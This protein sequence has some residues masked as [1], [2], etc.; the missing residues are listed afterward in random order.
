MIRPH[1]IS[2]AVFSNRNCHLEHFDTEQCRGKTRQFPDCVPG[3]V[4]ER[5]HR[6]LACAAPCNQQQQIL[7]QDIEAQGICSMRRVCQ[8]NVGAARWLGGE[9]RHQLCELFARGDRFEAIRLLHLTPTVGRCPRPVRLDGAAMQR[10]GKP[11][12]RT[13]QQ[14]A[15]TAVQGVVEIPTKFVSFVKSRQR[16]S[17]WVRHIRAGDGVPEFDP[18]WPPAQEELVAKHRCI[19]SQNPPFADWL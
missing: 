19:R 3:G 12:D 16:S 10:G 15:A 7:L 9:V 17:L 18:D 13:N 2:R 4:E 5:S 14:I 11:F 6:A 1:A 8:N